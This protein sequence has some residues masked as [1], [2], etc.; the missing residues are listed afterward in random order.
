MPYHPTNAPSDRC[1]IAA[2]RYVRASAEI[3]AML[4]NHASLPDDDP[5]SAEPLW[6]TLNERLLVRND[7]FSVEKGEET[8]VLI[9]PS[10][11]TWA[12]IS[13]GTLFVDC[14]F[15]WL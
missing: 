13:N 8:L 5:I 12:S 15:T 6:F 3:F 2:H 1:A 14:E 11:V 4:G 9:P 7:V 10:T